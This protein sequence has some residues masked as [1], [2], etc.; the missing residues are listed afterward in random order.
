MKHIGIYSILMAACI[1]TSCHPGEKRHGAHDHEG[2]EKEN[3][4][5][6]LSVRF[7]FKSKT[8]HNLQR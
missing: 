1:M 3:E 8:K 2:E 4:L 7:L 6:F 5:S